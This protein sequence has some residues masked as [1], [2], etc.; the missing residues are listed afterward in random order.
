M[1]GSNA[2]ELVLT[3]DKNQMISIEAYSLD[4]NNNGKCTA[5]QEDILITVVPPPVVYIVS[6]KK[7][8]ETICSGETITLTAYGAITYL[9]STGE[10][11]KSIEVT[12][13]VNSTY[14]VE[15]ADSHGC[16]NTE[17]ITLS[18]IK[19]PLNP[20]IS[21]GANSAIL[22][23][24]DGKP[25]ICAGTSIELVASADVPGGNYTYQWK[26]N[27]SD[28]PSVTVTPKDGET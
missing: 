17:Y 15:G 12:P 23:I 18:N 4:I 20:T 16:T 19:P 1:N 5:K 24:S 27:S 21:I 9:W 7:S 3:P 8:T 13:D 22:D 2:R 28:L 10:T 25:E 11:S 6:S 14:W 26:H